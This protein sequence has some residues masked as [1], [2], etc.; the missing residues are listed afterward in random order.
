[1]SECCKCGITDFQITPKQIK[2]YLGEDPD[3]NILEDQTDRMF[4]S[5]EYETICR[6]CDLN[7]TKGEICQTKQ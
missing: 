4:F 2:K 7:L 3:K 5:V 6:M 1:M